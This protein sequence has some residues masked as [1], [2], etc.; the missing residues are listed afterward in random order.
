MENQGRYAVKTERPSEHD[1]AVSSQSNSNTAE[2]Q[3]KI[4]QLQ[5]KQQQMQQQMAQM[6]QMLSA[7]NGAVGNGNLGGDSSYPCPGFGQLPFKRDPEPSFQSS[8]SV[9]GSTASSNESTINNNSEGT[10]LLTK[11]KLWN[12]YLAG[13]VS[14]DGIKDV[15]ASVHH[16]EAADS[17]IEEI[18]QEE[19]D[20]SREGF[21]LNDWDLVFDD[22][23]IAAILCEPCR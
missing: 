3:A 18:V 23:K 14:L 11:E 17:D 15:K 20:P 6:M 5:F 22:G 1:D 12:L 4:Q 16:S 19:E 21:S 10:E 8:S 2:E 7:Q 13:R 9:N